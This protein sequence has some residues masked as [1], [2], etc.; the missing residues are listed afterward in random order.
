[1]YNVRYCKGR[2][3]CI[4]KMKRKT[5]IITVSI[6][7]TI[8][9]FI[10]IVNAV[11]TLNGKYNK[12]VELIDK[13]NI[14][15]AYE[16]LV[17]LGG[18][19]DSEDKANSI[20]FEYEVEKLKTAEPGDHVFFGKYEQDNDTSNGKENIEWYVLDK[21]DNKVFV[22]SEYALDCKPYNTSDT[23]VTWESCTLRKWLNKG[24][25]KSAF[26]AAERAMIPT[27]NVDNKLKWSKTEDVTQDKVFLLSSTEI[28]DKYHVIGPCEA[29][30]Y[31]IANG[32][33]VYD[34]GFLDW[35]SGQC[36]WWLRSPSFFAEHIVN[37]AGIGG[38]IYGDTSGENICRGDRGVRP[39]MWI[40]LDK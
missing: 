26:S 23:T 40:E 13:G 2:E 25:I 7:C 27:V 12:A 18:Y 37:I 8:I 33:W 6:A 36:K 1:M 24:F 17:T 34:A 14:V 11:I 10:I 15:K 39:A 31:A 4:A 35:R 29:T 9:A 16:I 19:R 30:A 32:V 5:T 38:E 20:Y 3:R 28:R 21:Q 22:L